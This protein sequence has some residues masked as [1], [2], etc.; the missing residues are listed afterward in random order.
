MKF[1]TLYSFW[2]K[3]WTCDY[4][5][6]I[7]EVSN[8]GFDIL[9]IG[10]DH[11][12]NMNDSEISAIK[13]S[14]IENNIILTVNS[15]PSKD[16][17]LASENRETRENGI[18]YFKKIMDNMNKIGA[19]SLIGAI[20]SFWPC[21][22]VY[23]NKEVAWNNS[24]ECLKELAK[25]AESKDVLISLEVLNR[26]ETYI[27]TDCKEAIEYCNRIGSDNVKILLDTYHMNIE[28]DNMCESIR[29][30]NNMLGHIHVGENNRKLPG[31]N[32]SINW[33]ELGKTL[34]EINYKG[35]VVMEPFIVT[36]GDISKDIRVW[37][38]LNDGANT[39]AL[40]SEKIK[41]SLQFLKK[42]FLED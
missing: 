26:N 11:L 6:T 39:H 32:N 22:F 29:L 10:A 17:D 42:A 27:L 18:R 15:G 16:H 30:A 33:I 3:D 36:G 37:R 2:S 24:I 12:Y 21:D 34:R 7:K 20:Y 9:E 35:P 41:K 5:E 14:S 28:E 25:Y 13:E 38:D 40:M 19:H 1:G 23:T 31:T 8:I 4:V